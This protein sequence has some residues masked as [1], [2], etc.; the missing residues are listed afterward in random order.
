MELFYKIL[1]TAIDGGA[2]DIHLK[3]EGPVVFRISGE[4]IAVDSPS[5]T[6]EWI[7]QV[8]ELIVPP[9]L[10]KVL[11]EERGAEIGRAHV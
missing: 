11:A 6:K 7:D 5:P 4:L 9:H 1:K 8:V 2:S 3:V 10:T